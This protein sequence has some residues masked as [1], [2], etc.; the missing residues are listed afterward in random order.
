V[1]VVR[2]L[3]GTE[4]PSTALDLGDGTCE[5]RSRALLLLGAAGAPVDPGRPYGVVAVQLNAF[6]LTD[7]NPIERPMALADHGLSGPAEEFASR[8]RSFVFCFHLRSTH[9]F[10]GSRL[11]REA[12]FTE[13]WP[14]DPGAVV[15][16]LAESGALWSGVVSSPR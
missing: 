9:V 11:A 7:V 13:Q 15:V 10:Q 4:L 5:G 2:G 14:R 3:E 16:E 6:G 12:R 1:A 8:S